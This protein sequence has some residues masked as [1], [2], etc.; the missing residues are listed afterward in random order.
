MIM[1]YFRQNLVEDKVI[2]SQ[3]NTYIVICISYKY[4][5]DFQQGGAKGKSVDISGSFRIQYSM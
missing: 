1:M 4:T 3:K 5:T 2:K